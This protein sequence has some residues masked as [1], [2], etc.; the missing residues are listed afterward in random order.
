MKR[1]VKNQTKITTNTHPVNQV[2]YTI[3]LL[4]FSISGF[5]Q[6]IIVPVQK[7]FTAGKN[8]NTYNARTQD[9]APISLPFW[10]D[11]STIR[12]GYADS[13][14]WQY[15]QSVWVNEGMGINPPSLNV[16]TFDGLDSLGRP[17]NVNDILA[18][19]YADKLIS[20]PIRMD[21][22]APAQQA[23]IAITFFYEFK[24]NGGPDPGDKFSLSFKNST[25][26]WDE[27]WS[28]RITM[29]LLRAINL[30]LLLFPL[31]TVSIFLTTFNSDFKILPV[32][33]APMT[34]GIWIISTSTTENHKPV[35]CFHYFQIVL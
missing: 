7:D 1:K 19:G 2:V 13:T 11:F 33:Q 15:G 26:E 3:L 10:D 18:K 20:A 32:Y 9:I 8:Y 4:T 16:A 27:V 30:L 34:P 31:L 12:N 23:N 25:N 28:N 14:L 6:L 24:G 29:V 5:C 21:L 17:Y 22:V 35:R